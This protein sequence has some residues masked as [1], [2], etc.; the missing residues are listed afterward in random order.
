MAKSRRPFSLDTIVIHVGAMLGDPQPNIHGLVVKP[1][2]QH[3]GVLTLKRIA[4]GANPKPT[5]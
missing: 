1:S 5:I 4:H 2:L 3:L